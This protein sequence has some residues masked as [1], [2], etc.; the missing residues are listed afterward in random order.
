ME[1]EIRMSYRE[2]EALKGDLDRLRDLEKM[3]QG[4][5]DDKLIMVLTEVKEYGETNRRSL[6][7]MGVD[8]MVKSMAEEVQNANDKIE[9]LESRI[10]LNDSKLSANSNVISK[11]KNSLFY[12][13]FGLIPKKYIDKLYNT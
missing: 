13:T 4:E 9:L 5:M 7:S 12:K 8:A 6:Y 2:Y 3:F 1:K 11:I 10:K